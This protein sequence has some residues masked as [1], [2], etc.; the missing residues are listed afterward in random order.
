MSNAGA[1]CVIALVE[2]RSAPVAAY[3]VTVSSEMPPDTS[4]A[5]SGRELAR[6]S[7]THAATSSVVMLS[8]ITMSAPAATASS[9]W[10]ARSHS[11]STARPGHSSFAR[12]TASAMPSSARWLSFTSTRSDSEPRWFTPPPARTAAFSS[13]RR[14]GSVLRVS[15]MRA[16]PPAAAASTN[17][18]VMVAIPERWHRKLSAV[19]SPVSTGRRGPVTTP[20]AV[21]AASAAPSR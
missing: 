8:S 3:A 15:R 7:L 17:R 21:P 19:R 11:T 5:V 13:A 20:M 10:S 4:S 18:R 12:F 14:P 16:S 2:M 9:T 6:T 1:D